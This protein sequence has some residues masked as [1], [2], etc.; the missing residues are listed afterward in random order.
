[1][2]FNLLGIYCFYCNRYC[3]PYTEIFLNILFEGSVTCKK[4]HLLG[5]T[6]DKCWKDLME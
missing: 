6:C 3:N 2:L 1:M 4:D 5:R